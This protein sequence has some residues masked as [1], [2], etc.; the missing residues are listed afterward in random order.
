V[1]PVQQPQ[2]QQTANVHKPPASQHPLLFLFERFEKPLRCIHCLGLGI[3]EDDTAIKA[4]LVLFDGF[5]CCQCRLTESCRQ[6]AFVTA[7]CGCYGDL[8]F[9]HR[10]GRWSRHLPMREALE[11]KGVRVFEDN[12]GLLFAAV[13]SLQRADSQEPLWFAYKPVTRSAYRDVA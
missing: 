11:S 6:I 4:C 10:N 3:P 9:K 5:V 7:R 13:G 12:D 1:N 8:A 2:Q